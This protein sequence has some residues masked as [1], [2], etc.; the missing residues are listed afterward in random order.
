VLIVCR[1]YGVPVMLEN[2]Y[3]IMIYA[4]V[5]GKTIVPVI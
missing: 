4:L 2:Q 5:Y 1:E 3:P